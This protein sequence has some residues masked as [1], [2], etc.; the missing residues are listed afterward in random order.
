MF[1]HF[2]YYDHIQ[3]DKRN[4]SSNIEPSSLKLKL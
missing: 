1:V 4:D 2:I 3:D